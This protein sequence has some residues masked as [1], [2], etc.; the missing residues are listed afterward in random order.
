[1]GK[2]LVYVP[3]CHSTNTLA[4]DLCQ[5]TTSEEGTVIITDNQ[6]KGRGQRGNEWVSEPYKNLTFSLIVKP[7]FLKP[8]DQFHLTIAIS[9]ALRDFLTQ[10]VSGTVKIKWPN[11][12][13]LND[14]KLGGI[15][16][17]NSLTGDSIQYSVVG[18]GLNVNQE[19]FTMDSASSMKVMAGHD[20]ELTEELSLVMEFLEQR[21]LQLRSGKIG[22]LRNDYLNSLYGKGEL[23]TFIDA[24]GEWRGTIQDV[25]HR[26]KL[27]I[28]KP[29]GIHSYDL[30]EIRFID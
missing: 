8:I 28:A 14:K 19:N 2:N 27:L 16:I 24:S 7:T 17:E 4:F 25:N 3:E 18:I 23:R 29:G 30:K 9:L 15:L 26:G 21:Y 20:F 5:R 22:E 12:I 6:I 10:R 1:M 13:L 11:D